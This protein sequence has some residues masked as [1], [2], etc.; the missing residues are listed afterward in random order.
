MKGLFLFSIF[1][2]TYGSLFP[3]DFQYVNWQNDGIATLFSSSLF[4][5]ETPDLLGNIILF[6]PFGFAGTELISRNKLNKRFNYYLYTFGITLA[7]LLQI[8]QIFLDFRVPALYDALWNGVGIFFGV[9]LARFMNKKYPRILEAED[10][11]ALLALALSWVIFLL[12]PFLFHFNTEIIA[13]NIRV[14]LDINEHRLAN[15]IFYVAIWITFTKLIDEL[16]P[17]GRNIFLSLEFLVLFTLTAKMFVY[18]DFLEPE[19]L[20]GGILAII[21]M[22]TGLFNKVSPYKIC[23]AILVPVM[24][25]N[26]IY[27]LEFWNN[28][29]KEFMWIPFSELFSGDMLPIIRTVFYKTFAYGA[30][31]WTLYKSFPNANWINYFCVFYAGLI[32][33]V[34]HLT[35]FRIGGLTEPLIVLFLVTFIHQNRDKFDLYNSEKSLQN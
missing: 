26:S 9:L 3:F 30:I 17:M 2:I 10:R 34:Q 11:L 7:V 16:R 32:E 22:R 19:L 8:L 27:P 14:H 18:R 28:P 6:L 20:S 29:F 24:F 21:I 13:E 25:Y 1:V 31:V 5:S 15:V 4:D 35:A 12:V 33:Y 23:A